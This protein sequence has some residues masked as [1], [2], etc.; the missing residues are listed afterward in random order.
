MGFHMKLFANISLFS[1][2]LFVGLLFCP[3]NVL[4]ATTDFQNG[5]FVKENYDASKF[6]EDSLLLYKNKAIEA[7]NQSNLEEA[8]YYVDEYIKYSSELGFVESRYFQKFRN[9]EPFLELRDSYSFHFDWLDFLYL[10]SAVTGFFIGIV[11]LLRKGQDRTAKVL[12]SVFVLIHSVFIFHIFLYN[13]NLVYQTPHVLYMSAGFSYLYGPLIYF[14]Y[15]RI[16]T[17][18]VFKILDLLH[19]LPTVLTLV[20]IFPILLLPA[21]DKLNI[22]LN[23]GPFN[24]LPYL[25]GVVATKALSLAIYGFLLFQLYMK[26]KEHKNYSL[27]A[28]RWLNTIVTLGI[29]YVVSYIIYGLTIS[30]IIPRSDILYHL[31]IVFMASMVLYIGYAS[32]LRPNLFVGTFGKRQEK[33]TKSGLTTDYSM[34]LKEILVDLM[35]NEKLYLKND[36]SLDE[37]SERMDTTRHNA[38]QVINEHFGLNFFELINKYRIR[39][40]VELLQKDQKLSIIDVAYQVGF[41]NKVTFNK[42]FK[43]ILSKTPTQY[44]SSLS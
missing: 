42:S 19:L 6:S 32:Y 31:Q 8:A 27:Q 15:K 41:N 9:T 11:L 10:F 17:K 40:A 28:Q 3:D 20:L 16:T 36:I 13:T 2:V 18:Y 39:D 43:K 22:M 37:L 26:N 38:S 35:E 30:D 21:Q 44:L 14:Y 33:Y 34:E 23:V 12:I 24:R 25:Y 7:A 5:M 29:A 1:T 4:P